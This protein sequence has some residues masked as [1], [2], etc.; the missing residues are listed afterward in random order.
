[1][2]V[3]HEIPTRP[4]AKGQAMTRHQAWKEAHR[5]WST[6]GTGTRD[7]SAWV[8]IRRKSA[9][10]RFVVG[11]FVGAHTTSRGRAESIEMG[12]GRSWEEAFARA[13]ARDPEGQ[14]AG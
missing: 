9:A 1:M 6:H 11:F 13:D 12:R 7:R 4:K 2:P 14:E 5:R 10:D 3:T 8:S